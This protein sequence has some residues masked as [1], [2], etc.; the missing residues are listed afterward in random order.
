M[1]KKV[2]PSHDSPV[3][4]DNDKHLK[5]E[6]DSLKCCHLPDCP[7]ETGELIKNGGFE[8]LSTDDFQAFAHWKA[9]NP[10]SN[11]IVSQAPTDM[12]PVQYEGIRAA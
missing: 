8:I 12:T 10:V 5:I 11:T 6:I 4:I 2:Q 7:C 9:V 1:A 3:K